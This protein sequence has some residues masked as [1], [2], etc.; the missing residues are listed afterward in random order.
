M[1]L[2]V[3]INYVI[4]VKTNIIKAIHNNFKRTN[5]SCRIYS[6]RIYAICIYAYIP[7]KASYIKPPSLV[8]HE[9]FCFCKVK[10][11]LHCKT[12]IFWMTCIKV[13]ILKMLKH[14]LKYLKCFWNESFC[15]KVG[16]NPHYK[17]SSLTRVEIHQWSVRLHWLTR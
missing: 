14:F 5:T 12:K 16:K 8:Y 9:S 4:Y 3:L 2:P 11:I 13:V 10:N 17:N 6:S 7:Y 15:I 1:L